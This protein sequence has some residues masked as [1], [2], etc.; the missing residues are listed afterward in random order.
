VTL[1]IVGLDSWRAWW[2]GLGY[3]A[4]SQ[5]AAPALYGFSYAKLLPGEVYSVLC[6]AFLG[7]ALLFRGR[8]GLAALGL[9]SIFASPSLW[10]HGFVF[11]LPAVLMLESGAA[12]WMILGAGAFGPN[13]WLL[14]M[15]GWVAVL[16]ARRMPTG[17]LHPLVGRDGPWPRPTRPRPS[18]RA[19]SPPPAGNVGARTRPPEI[20]QN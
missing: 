8:P 2:D 17:R 19:T 6:V 13:M 15:A 14:F 11:A 16:G 1:P 7:L 4:A 12:V 9:V 5:A 10:P 18:R 20:G 3:R